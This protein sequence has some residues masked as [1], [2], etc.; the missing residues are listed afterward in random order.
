LISWIETATKSSLVS[1][2]PRKNLLHIDLPTAVMRHCM[3]NRR[4]RTLLLGLLLDV[5]SQRTRIV[6][7]R[8]YRGLLMRC[9]RLLWRVCKRWCACGLHRRE[10]VL[11]ALGIERGDE[12]LQTW[13]D[14]ARRNTSSRSV[15]RR[16]TV[17]RR[18]A[19]WRHGWH[20]ICR[21]S[22][23]AVAV[24]LGRELLRLVTPHALFLAQDELHADLEIL[25]VVIVEFDVVRTCTGTVEEA[26][27]DQPGVLIRTTKTADSK[28][29]LHELPTNDGIEVQAWAQ[30]E[31]VNCE[32]A[33]LEGLLD[34]V[35][36][37]PVEILV[38]YDLHIRNVLR[39]ALWQRQAVVRVGRT[40]TSAEPA[41]SVVW[42]W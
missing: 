11:Q 29:S 10:Q 13:R 12:L 37:V 7:Q 14:C 24:R 36:E 33:T 40:G 6:L 32:P 5:P 15:R 18:E 9:K 2:Q 42:R 26:K 38:G 34:P 17:T 1:S 3:L 16:C 19:R 8:C 21:L 4:D 31:N 28:D 27:I 20:T 22:L 25:V 39:R 41:S 23:L 30:V 35:Y